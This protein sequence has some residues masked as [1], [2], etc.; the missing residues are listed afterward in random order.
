MSTTGSSDEPI[1]ID[2]SAPFAGHVMD[3]QQLGQDV[4][5]QSDVTQIC[6]QWQDFYDPDSNIDR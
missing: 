4:C 2:H 5:C 3:G 1:L 6:V